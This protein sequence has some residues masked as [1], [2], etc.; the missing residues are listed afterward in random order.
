MAKRGKKGK[1]G[2]LLSLRRAL[3]RPVGICAC[4]V[5]SDD[6]DFGMLLQP[7]FQW[8]SFSPLQQ[9]NRTALLQIHQNFAVMMRCGHSEFG[10]RTLAPAAGVAREEDNFFGSREE[11]KFADRII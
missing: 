3:A 2:D 10:Q 8:R 9:V 5:A 1:I 6:L 7:F 4:E 11:S